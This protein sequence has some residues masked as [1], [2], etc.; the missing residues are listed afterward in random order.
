[1]G[2]LITSIPPLAISAANRRPV[3]SLPAG[4]YCGHAVPAG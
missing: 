1:V 2:G 3:N 4:G